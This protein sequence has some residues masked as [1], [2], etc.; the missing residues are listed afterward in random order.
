MISRRRVLRHAAIGAAFIGSPTIMASRASAA[1]EKA[2][3]IAFPTDLASWDAMNAVTSVTQSLYKCVF[4][5]LLDITPT[6]QL[7]PGLGSFKWLDNNNQ[8]LELTLRDNLLFHNGDPLTSDDVH[9][10]FYTRLKADD[11]LA[12]AANFGKIVEAVETPA[13]NKVVF[14]FASKYI[15]AP[16]RLMAVGYVMP[17][18]YT[19]SVG[20]DG[21]MQKP[22][23]AGPYK[24]VD[25]QRG[26]RIVLEAHDKYYRGA[27]SI[28]QVV[29]QIVQD[30][31]TR[32]AAVQSGQ[33]DFAHNLPVREVVRLGAIPGLVG[34]LHPISS[35]YMIHMVNKGIYQDPNVRLAMHHAINTA[36]LSKAFF[37]GKAD[38]L[39]MWAGPGTPA[40]DPNFKFAYSPEMAKALLAK[41]GYTA[42]NPAKIELLSPNGVFQND[43]DMARTIVQMWKEIGI[44]AS[45][46]AIELPK[47]NELLRTDKLESPMLYNWFNPTDDPESYSGSIMNPKGR[48]SAWKSDDITPKLQ[49]LLD[50][51]NYDKR[52]A[53]Y[54]EFDRWTVEQGYAC[55]L[56]QGI[57][58][59]VYSKRIRYVPYRTG[60]VAP[61][62][63]TLTA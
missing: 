3:S 39:S 25:Y 30:P 62:A 36:G 21:F 55:P 51:T 35:V 20:I 58:T 46:T 38:V 47:F 59:V 53:G 19:E 4:D 17:R 52:M 50:E 27:P 41:S 14:K 1:N 60:L 44:D 10:S 2:I 43:F 16:Q 57:A 45:A 6:A 40:N 13:P 34:N 5:S 61:Y 26:S 48:F 24:L 31:S 8:V 63:W 33:V 11:T 42:K 22:V 18:R 32:I 15:T 9:F 12:V 54:R 49:A 37:N 29:I 23:G 28:K 7:Q 56:L